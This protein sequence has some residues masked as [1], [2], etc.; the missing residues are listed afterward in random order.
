MSDDIKA[1]M[2][3]IE[4]L[5]EALGPLSHQ[6][7][8]SVIDYVFKRL[9]IAGPTTPAAVSLAPAL[10]QMPSGTASQSRTTD[11]Q[12]LKDEKQPKTAAEMVAVMA[13]YLAHCAAENEARDY[14]TAD[15]I[16]KYFVQAHFELPVARAQTLVNAKNAGYLDPIEK[17]RYRLN[18][19]GHNLVAHKMPRDGASRRPATSR[20]RA[21]RKVRKNK[22]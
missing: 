6:A 11:I 7:R 19:V 14:I 13:Y 16:K 12:S 22:T 5:L 17:G 9:G 3:A 4:T 1:E 15:D 18:S 10:Q 8:E 20:T 2:K 21:K